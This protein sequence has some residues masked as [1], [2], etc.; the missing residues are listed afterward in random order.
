MN[1]KAIK[2][3]LLAA[4]AMVLVA[5]LALGSSTYAWFV[6]SGTV[7]ATGMSVKAQSEGG[8]AISFDG[9]QWGT[10]ATAGMTTKELYPAST[11]DLTDWYHATAANMNAA[12]AQPGSRTNITSIVFGGDSGAY[13]PNNSYVVMREFQIKSSSAS[14]AS[15]G[16]FVESVDVT[17]YKTMSTALRVGVKY[18][19]ASGQPAAV[20]TGYKIYAPVSL[21]AGAENNPTDNYDVYQEKTDDPTTSEVSL[22]KVKLDAVG[23]TGST[24][25]ASD[26]EIPSGTPLTVQIYI[27]FEGED[28][29]LKSSNFHPED[30]SVTVNFSSISGGTTSSSSVS[31]TGAIAD[32][33]AVSATDPETGSAADFYKITNK[34]GLNNEVLYAK[35]SGELTSGN[36]YTISGGAATQY[37]KVTW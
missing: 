32:T 17:G 21:G 6:A 23:Q 20:G 35:A 26:G 28:A 15:K 5:A 14:D 31:M 7:T 12:G 9:E 34:T 29:N 36:I 4:I 24:L 11:R 18:V 10:T 27:W 19:V 22:G 1:S 25:I 13:A 3:Q 33:T 8:L 37:T 2:R 30:L 16:L